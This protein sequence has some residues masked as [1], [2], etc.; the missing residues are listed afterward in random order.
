MRNKKIIWSVVVAL[1]LGAIALLIITV[2]NKHHH[3][4]QPDHEGH[5]Q[6]ANHNANHNA[7]HGNKDHNQNLENLDKHETN[8]SEHGHVSSHGHE[9]KAAQ[10]VG[11]DKEIALSE[12]AKKFIEYQPLSRYALGQSLYRVPRTSV[13]AYRNRK[14]V[15]VRTQ[16]GHYRFVPAKRAGEIRSRRVR[17]SLSV[18]SNVH[19]VTKG[20]WLLRLAYLS[21]YESSPGGHVH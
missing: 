21:L 18:P 1:V 8:G 16:Q 15:F 9:A 20:G 6:H 19:L 13:I 7:N 2:T 12:K 4:H 17:L 3:E 11:S 10:K 14:A 5:S